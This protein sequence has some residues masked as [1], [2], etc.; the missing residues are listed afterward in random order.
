MY[1]VKTKGQKWQETSTNLFFKNNQCP[2]LH[3]ISVPYYNII[4]CTKK[5]VT[6]VSW[7]QN[8]ENVIHLLQRGGQ[9]L[10][11]SVD[12]AFYLMSCLMR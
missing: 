4:S 7:S 8:Y 5:E 9:I 2:G 12:V 3:E 11:K 10:D 6:P 1:Q